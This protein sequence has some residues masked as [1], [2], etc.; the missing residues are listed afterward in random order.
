[1]DNN[2]RKLL[3]QMGVVATGLQLQSFSSFVQSSENT[4][5]T[6]NVTNKF[7][8]KKN[9]NWSTV[10]QEF[11]LDENNIHFANFLITSHPRIVRDD[12]NYHRNRIDKN[13]AFEMHHESIAHHESES[14][15]WAAR[16]L[17]VKSSQ[18]A[19]TGSTTEGLGLIYNGLKIA[20][21]QE[22]LTSEHEHWAT[23]GAL[24]FRSQRDDINIKTIKLFSDPHHVSTDEVLGS[25]SSN[26]TDKTRVLALT[27]V[28]SGSG[29]KLPI[30]EIGKLVSEKNKQREQE[31]KIIFCVD[32]VH[33]LGVE[34]TSFAELNCDFLIAGTHKWMFGPRGTGIICSRSE[35][36]ENL[37]PTIDT[38]SGQ[39]NFGTIM[40]PGG[41][42]AF[43]HQWAMRKA[44]EFHLMLGKEQIQQRIHQ[45]NTLL[46]QQLKQLGSVQLVTPES[47][48]YSAGF[49]F[50]R[51][52][53]IDCEKV[54]KYLQVNRVA[55][56]ATN[57]DVGPV[58]RMSPGLINSEQ[59]IEY[60]IQLL[61]KKIA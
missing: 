36:I 43:E 45:L 37:I 33:G 14:R 24:R 58:I 28:H 54:A 18:I 31:N 9:I 47:T 13:P 16:Y 57:R 17:K 35:Q 21:N 20:A 38:F 29:V 27:W 39:D 48:K 10:R 19:L 60:V 2:K 25:I 41:F 44:F 6:T 59:E 40:T 55:V 4:R 3:K 52:K 7:L 34:N 1:M 8:S 5:L 53:N 30:S 11:N 23:K 51:V 15:D 56:D 49:T 46:K 42:H 22:V 12:I 61:A 50:F 32:G 26:I